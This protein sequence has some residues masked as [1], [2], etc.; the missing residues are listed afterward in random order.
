ERSFA[1]LLQK[2]TSSRDHGGP[3]RRGRGGRGRRPRTP[4]AMSESYWVD[5]TAPQGGAQAPSGE[6]AT[7]NPRTG[8]TGLAGEWRQAPARRRAICSDFHENQAGAALDA[9][10]LGP[11]VRNHVAGD[12]LLDGLNLS[13]ALLYGHRRPARARGGRDPLRRRPL[14]LAPRGPL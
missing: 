4:V 10:V 5:R 8:E 14:F 9:G 3:P 7:R 6:P 1:Y 11:E 13:L 12:A 2:R